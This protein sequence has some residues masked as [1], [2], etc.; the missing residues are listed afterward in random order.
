MSSAE[1]GADIHLSGPRPPQLREIT[2]N[3]SDAKYYGRGAEPG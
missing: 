3:F 1:A 2:L